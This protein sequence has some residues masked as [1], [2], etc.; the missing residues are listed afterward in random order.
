MFGFG[1]RPDHFTELSVHLVE[2]WHMRARHAKAFISAYRRNISELHEAGVGRFHSNQVPS[3]RVLAVGRDVDPCDF[4]LVKQAYVA[5]MTDLRHGRHLGTDV[6]LAI[7][8]ILAKRSDLVRPIDSATAKF[9]EDN[10]EL[11]FPELFEIV[12]TEFPTSCP[13]VLHQTPAHAGAAPDVLVVRPELGFL[14]LQSAVP[15][16]TGL[17]QGF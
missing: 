14:T 1:Y 11:L 15:P 3:F 12:F 4:S 13:L 5:Y 16:R 10:W 2:K 8:A 9:F 6:E 17:P 7:W